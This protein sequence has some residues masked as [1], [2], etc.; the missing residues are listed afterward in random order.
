MPKYTLEIGGKTYDIES[1]KSLSDSDLMSYAK[2]IATPAVQPATTAQPRG[3]VPAEQPRA[4]PNI[5]KL[6][7]RA[8]GTPTAELGAEALQGEVT[9]PGAIVS[10]LATG[11]GGGIVGL[12]EL[13]ARAVGAE[14]V[15]RAAQAIRESS[16]ANIAPYKEAYPFITG[17]SEF[18]GE[19]A[20]PLKV[21]GAMG[22]AV[23]AG[24]EAVPAVARFTTPLAESIASGGFKTGLLPNVKNIPVAERVAVPFSQKMANMLAMASGGALGTA[25]TTAILEGNLENVLP[26]AGVGAAVPIALPA[27]GRLG[28]GALSKSADYLSGMAPVVKA[29]EIA[30]N[31]AGPKLEQIKTLL[32]ASPELGAG[33]AA[34]DANRAAW[35]ALAKSAAEKDPTEFLRVLKETQ[36]AAQANELV[37]LAGGATQQASL[38]AQKQ[39]KNALNKMLGPVME[40]ELKAAGEAGKAY[41]EIGPKIQQKYES[42]ADALQQSGQIYAYSEQARRALLNK[43]NSP[44]PGWVSAKT[45]DDLEQNVLKARTAAEE[46]YAMKGQR[47]DEMAFLQRQLDSLKAHGLQPIDTSNIVSSISAK[48]KDPKVGVSDENKKVLTAVADKI[49]EWTAKGEGYIDPVA[50]HEIRKNT[51]NEVINKELA[52]ADPSYIKRQASKVL[53]EVKPLIDDA[54]ENAGGTRWRKSLNAYSNLTERNVTRKEFAA[55]AMDL[56]QKSPAKFVELVEGNNPELVEAVF[57]YGKT[58]IKKQ[59]GGQYGAL[60]KI[61]DEVKRDMR[62]EELASEGMKLADELIK[63]KRGFRFPTLLR[64]E[65][66][67]TNKVLD[68]LESNVSEKTKNALIEGLRTGESANKLLSIFPAGERSKILQ[69]LYQKGQKAASPATTVGVAQRYSQSE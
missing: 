5:S 17:A 24:G 31:V 8:T 2:Q 21:I 41:R 54:I 62:S 15:Q 42:M 43:I 52:G 59:M 3:T 34:V 29:A 58:D 9:L 47:Q 16:K 57:G 18:A 14:D 13:G 45:I 36:G 63:Q 39:A 65:L 44:T 27:L 69:F 4:I 49:L 51:V 37:R 7:M 35:Q 20:I 53:S 10:G 67:A 19:M 68:I 60:K 40:T 23:R 46:M 12:T 6:G 1:E 50:L 55:E 66:A 61:S 22:K 32:S 28:Y 56:Y 33:Q 11:V 48:L 26:S 38:E 64:A 25:G 30:R